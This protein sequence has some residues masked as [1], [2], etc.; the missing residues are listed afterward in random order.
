ML[1]YRLIGINIFL[2]SFT[3]GVLLSND[4]DHENIVS[5]DTN[6]YEQKPNLFVVCE[7]KSIRT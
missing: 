6:F 5:I 2:P 3:M 4:E 7:R 1:F